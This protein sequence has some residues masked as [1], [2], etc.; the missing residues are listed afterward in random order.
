[1]SHLRSALGTFT[2]LVAA[3]GC[4]TS[5]SSAGNGADASGTPDS[6]PPD[7][8][9]DAPST[10]S[11]SVWIQGAGKK[12][13]PS[14][15]APPAGSP[16]G[17]SLES[18]RDATIA[19]QVVV[20]AKGG[21]LRGVKVSPGDLADGAGHVLKAAE[22]TLFREAFI[23]MTGVTAHGGNV[24]V[25]ANS[26]SM[27]GKIP[28]ALIPLIDPYTAADAG[29]P[30]DVWPEQNQPLFLDVHVPKGT[31]A[32]TYTGALHVTA[33][34][35][36]ALDV[37][38]S[39]SVL[40]LDLPDMRSVTTHFKLSEND[41]LQY[42]HGLAACSGT[43]C[44]LDSN[45]QS[46]MVVKRYEELA[47]AHR[48]DVG[49]SF[50]TEPVDA[51]KVPTD[52]SAYDA[53]VAP[54]MDGSYFADHVPSSRLTVPFSP[55]VDYGLEKC[56]QAEYT[57]IA[58]AWAT[59]LKAKGWFDRAIVYAA[60]EPDPATFPQIAKNSAWMQAGDPA[61]LAHVMDTTAPDPTD[62]ATLNPA[63]GIYCVALAWY[64]NWNDHGPLYGRKEWPGLFA[65][66]KKLWFYESNAQDPP[67]VTFASNTLDGLEPTLM[68]WGSWYEHATGFLYW[69]VAAWDTKDPWGPAIAF[70]KTGDGVLLYPGNHDGQL[71]GAGSPP[72]VAIDGPI[73][74][75]RLKMVR[76]GLQ[77]W[78]L[79]ALAES[80]GL[81]AM[82]RTEVAKVYSQLGGCTYAGCPAPAGGFFWKS[83]EAAMAQIRKTVVAAILAKP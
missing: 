45:A 44:W 51:C 74:S 16:T 64:D 27:D 73:P 55:G 83:D 61:W 42:H 22:L 18:Y 72:G 13:Q 10:G 47:H 50:V 20:R 62:V 65:Q 25:P 24:P 26:P 59:H 82:V 68:M 60:D 5:G 41:L 8:G 52:W 46:R 31:P 69:D 21:D 29:Q 1:M 3:S 76:Q 15:A 34:G 56:S 81:G 33:T 75:Y 43:D 48:I 40:A 70:N 78:A 37:P 19:A 2:F 57:A 23:D 39:L 32:G 7:F 54:Y 67:Y 80:K 49:Q 36:F 30:F 58:K 35:G 53:A 17:V 9:V 6:G 79:F 63:L 11:L 66:G 77:D 12:V 14:T 4:G 38:V 71:A 28:D